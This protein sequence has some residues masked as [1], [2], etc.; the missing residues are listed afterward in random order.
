MFS[1]ASTCSTRT[2]SAPWHAVVLQSVG[3]ELLAHEL[4]E[5][6]VEQELDRQYVVADRAVGSCEVGGVPPDP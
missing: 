5:R 2:T 6:L 4:V 3:Q 1:G